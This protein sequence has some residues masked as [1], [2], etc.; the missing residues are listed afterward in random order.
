MSEF[1]YNRFCLKFIEWKE[2]AVHK[3]T[4]CWNCG[5]ISWKWRFI[6]QMYYQHNRLFQSTTKINLEIIQSTGL[7]ED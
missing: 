1:N 5:G 2:A 6:Q 3:T 4:A 7:M